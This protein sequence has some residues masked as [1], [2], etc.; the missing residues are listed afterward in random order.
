M[1]TTPATL[2]PASAIYT[3]QFV[4]TGRVGRC[5]ADDM[6]AEFARSG[7]I[8]LPDFLS[9]DEL[10]PLRAAL[11]EHYRPL[12]DRAADLAHGRIGETARFECDVIAWDPVSEKNP[13]FVALHRHAALAAVTEVLLGL[14]FTEASSLVMFSIAGGRGQA[15]H[16][17]CPPEH[18]AAFNLN[19]LFYPDDVS[20]EDG[21][22]V[23]VP[24]SHRRGRIPPGGH[25]EPIDGEVALTPRAGTLVLLHGHVYH[26]VAANRTNRPR[27]SINFRAYAAG[28]PKSVN[29]IGIYRNGE[30]DF[31]E[32]SRRHAPSMAPR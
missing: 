30:I 4:E 22:V 27:T 9:P 29:C 28:V 2:T 12:A 32:K 1:P 16:Q 11:I 19:R 25:Q 14:G 10:P 7:C 23:V 15:W 6:R 20:D 5:S 21:A 3:M 31:C 26:R 13:A 8:I 24:G 17:D 18:V